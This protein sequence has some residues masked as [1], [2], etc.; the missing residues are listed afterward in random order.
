MQTEYFQGKDGYIWWNGVVED[1]KD[2]LMIGRCRVRILG[3]HTADKAELPTADLPWAQVVMPITSASQT[4]VGH[5]PVGPVEGTWVMGFYRDGELA[6]EP[7]M[8]GT[9][10]GIPENL[11]KINTGFNDSR[12]DVVD[13]DR[14]VI[15]KKGGAKPG[16]GA[17]SLTGWP[18]PL[19]KYTAFKGKEVTIVEYTNKERQDLT[20]KSLYPRRTNEPTTSRYARGEGDDSSKVETEGIFAT[21]NKN[22][23]K[24]KIS[25][26]FLPSTNLTKNIPKDGTDTNIFEPTNFTVNEVQDIQQAP[27]PYAAVYP[28]N[29]VY[30][31]ESGHL[32]EVDDTPTKERLHWYHRAGT[33]TEFHPKGSRTDR[34]TGHHYHMVTGN[35]ETIIS[36]LQK[37][38]IE[39]DSFTDYAKSKH[40]SLGNDF[41]VTSDNGDIILG[42]PSGHA[43]IAA[44][45]VI[46]DG[47]TS[48]TLNAPH[49]T[50]VNSTAIDTI[51][52]NY[53]LS[54][55]GGYNLQA[56][57]LTLG[58][59]GEANIT[60]FGNITQTI[61]G[62][63]EEVI[64]NIPGFGLGNLTAKKI[65]TTFGK[66]VLESFNP[67]GGI[68]LNMSM[69]GLMS[70]ISIA[71]P[72]GDIAIKTTSAPTGVTIDSLTLATI[73]G[74]IKVALEG[75]IIEL[76]A[77]ALVD[78]DGALITVGGKT[79]P[80]LL[81][82]TFLM[83]IFKDHQHPSSVG[84]TGPIM[85][86]YAAKLLKA[87][88]KKCFLG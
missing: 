62:S 21:K 12:L 67:L 53:A 85:P 46:L 1:R 35:A 19:K 25:S 56:G 77:D 57:K 18:F 44:N 43:V 54:A 26:V 66:I 71:P 88:S 73:K 24:G 8:V 17:I 80:M 74:L 4:G 49:I 83:D 48:L 33:F 58:S 51:K 52:G 10:P 13:V 9:L 61:G 70:Q 36:G 11:A 59:M 31:S 84:P 6:Q 39:N 45:H 5:T 72:L 32:I 16:G 81:G 50:R 65:K 29:H 30:E 69:A 38:I 75:A 86:Q 28:F 55:Q 34:V 23:G 37:R 15:T 41:V 87:M 20:G 64:A 60:T 68:D 42:A 76:K 79:E 47:G 22:L 2:P 63:S 40:Q 3:W 78:I 27:S 14:H 82:K 7:V